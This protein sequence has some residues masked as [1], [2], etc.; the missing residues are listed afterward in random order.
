MV[1][2]EEKIEAAIVL[3]VT[4]LPVPL[5]VRGEQRSGT[6]TSATASSQSLPLRQSCT[7]R[8]MEVDLLTGES[9]P[10]LF[11]VDVL[12]IAFDA[13]GFMDL[14]VPSE[15]RILKIGSALPGD[16]DGGGTVG[17]DDLPCFMAALLRLPDATLPIMTADM[18]GD[19]CAKGRHPT[20][21]RHVRAVAGT[22]GP[23][24]L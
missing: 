5:Q 15:D 17:L 10:F 13:E 6:V 4:E 2:D 11:G 24:W 8:M 3:Q 16:M 1:N 19:G 7:N 22:T 20:D 12:G 14:S 9:S 21:H 23:I 18:D